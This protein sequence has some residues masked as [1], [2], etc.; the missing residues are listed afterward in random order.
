ME[1]LTLLP[2]MLKHGTPYSNGPTCQLILLYTSGSYMLKAIVT[3]C[4]GKIFIATP[5][6]DKSSLQV[7]AVLSTIHAGTG[8]P[9]Y[10]IVGTLGLHM[11][12]SKASVEV[13]CCDFTLCFTMPIKSFFADVFLVK[14]LLDHKKEKNKP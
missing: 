12:L 14:P 10:I 4:I 5:K 3:Q 1:A 13:H 8:K 6:L 2:G 9:C 7:N 11:G